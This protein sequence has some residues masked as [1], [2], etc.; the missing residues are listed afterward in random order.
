MAIIQGHEPRPP[1]R[2]GEPVPFDVVITTYTLLHVG[3]ERF[4]V[5]IGRGDE[6]TAMGGCGRRWRLL[7]SGT[8]DEQIVDLHL[9]ER[10]P[11]EAG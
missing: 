10:D 5:P 1:A 7:T 9:R 6:V 4:V 11:A 8:I 3:A 2:S